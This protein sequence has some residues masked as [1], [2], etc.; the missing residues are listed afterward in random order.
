MKTY[1]VTLNFYGFIGC[2]ATYEV[3]ADSKEEAEELAK[4]EALW[5]LNATDIEEDEE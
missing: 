5:D 2:E 4:Q 3:D 1:R